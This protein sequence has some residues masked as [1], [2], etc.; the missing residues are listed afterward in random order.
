MFKSIRDWILLFL[1]PVY[2]TID[3]HI[4]HPPAALTDACGV[5]G[6]ASHSFGSLM[7]LLPVSHLA[8]AIGIMLA[9]LFAGFV[10]RL[11]RIAASFV[12]LGGGA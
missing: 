8:L 9:G 3:S 12:T 1:Q 11:I 6:G 4:P 7:T 2:V 5:I 10:I